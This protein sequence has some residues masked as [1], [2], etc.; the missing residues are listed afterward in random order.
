M[1]LWRRAAFRP[2][3]AQA[4]RLADRALPKGILLA[5]EPVLR[6]GWLPEAQDAPVAAISCAPRLCR[7]HSR[8]DLDNALRPNTRA[9]GTIDTALRRGSSNDHPVA[10]VVAQDIL[11][12]SVLAGGAGRLHAP[13]RS[14]SSACV[15]A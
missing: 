4:Q 1:S 5:L 11:A 12:E 13:G 6:R 10:R 2:V 15:H 8:A 14:K 7:H 3:S 9:G